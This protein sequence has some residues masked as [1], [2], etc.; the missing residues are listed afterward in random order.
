MGKKAGDK[1]K[2]PRGG[3]RI[4]SKLTQ[5]MHAK[6]YVLCSQAASALGVHRAS[7]YRWITDKKV[8]AI[9]VNGTYYVDWASCVTSY[10]KA[11]EVL[12]LDPEV[13]PALPAAAPPAS[14]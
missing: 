5:D 7:V 1:G 4:D 9:P 11:A 3:R 12:E 13:P 14:A 8:D 6:G 2:S 10:G